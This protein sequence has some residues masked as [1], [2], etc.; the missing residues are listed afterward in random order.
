MKILAINGSPRTKNSCTNKM[1]Q[2]LLKGMQTAG[3]ETKIL[4]LADKKIHHCI[5]CFNCWFKTPGSCVFQD[6]M[7]S[8]LKEMIDV[9]L[10]VFGTPLYYFNMTGLFK[11]FLDRTLPLASPYV[12]EAQNGMVTHPSRHDKSFK[13]LVLV[14]AGG[15]PETAHFDSLIATFKQ[16]AQAC[17]SEY[18]GAIVRPAASLMFIEALK[19]KANTYFNLLEEAGKQLI[20]Q[21]SIDQK[22]YQLLHE[23]WISPKDYLEKTNAHFKAELEKLHEN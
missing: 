17:N 15:F 18:I 20:E 4:H 1:L 16:V 19:D 2:C 22:T 13:K 6:D 8:L 3:A 5:G 23:E 10:V 9:D 11:N 14:S 21:N 7:E 12:E